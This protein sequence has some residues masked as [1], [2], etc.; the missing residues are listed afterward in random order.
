MRAAGPLTFCSVHTQHTSKQRAATLRVST[1][2]DADGFMVHLQADGTREL[3][4]D[5]L[6]RGCQRARAAVGGLLLLLLL[7]E[8]CARRDKAP[9]HRHHGAADALQIVDNSSVPAR[10][11][12]CSVV[13][14]L[15]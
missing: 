10:G 2:G 7:A 1:A 14:A 12:C 3:A 9:E 4:L 11:S 13:T 6:R 15:S 5:A 8:L